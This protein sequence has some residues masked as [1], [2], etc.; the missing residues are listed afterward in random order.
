MLLVRR[1]GSRNLRVVEPRERSAD[2][3]VLG[4]FRKHFEKI[5]RKRDA[6]KDRAAH[7][8]I[9]VVYFGFFCDAEGDGR[10]EVH[11]RREVE[12]LVRIGRR[13]GCRCAEYTP[14]MARNVSGKD[15][16]LSGG[17]YLFLTDLVKM[18]GSVIII[19]LKLE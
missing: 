10:L 16:N 14:C 18:V 11:L 4:G 12:E 3:R 17:S 19:S 6:S 5:I 15:L 9:A 2:R 7:R 8:V 1:G 13:D